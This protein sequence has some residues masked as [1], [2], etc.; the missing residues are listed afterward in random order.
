MPGNTTQSFQQE[1]NMVF[2]KIIIS[3]GNRDEM[4]KFKDELLDTYE[5][6]E[7]R[8]SAELAKLLKPKHFR[9]DADGNITRVG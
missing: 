4:M 3:Y 2:D 9:M 6:E 7:S 5:N 1:L 8:R